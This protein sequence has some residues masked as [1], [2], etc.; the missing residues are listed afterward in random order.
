M[1]ESLLVT[2]LNKG[3]FM[4]HFS[5]TDAYYGFLILI[6]FMF[7]CSTAQT[8][9]VE[10]RCPPECWVTKCHMHILPRDLGVEEVCDLG[11]LPDCAP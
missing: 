3:N 10:E 7:A 9:P 4:H 8:P 6:L 2:G 11:C 5:K 1:V